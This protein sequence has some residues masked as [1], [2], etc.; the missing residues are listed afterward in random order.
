MIYLNK[1]KI[2]DIFLYVLDTLADWEI[3]FLIAEI[4]SGRNLKKDIQLPKIIK[5]NYLDK[6]TWNEVI[7]YGRK[8]NIPPEQLDFPIFGL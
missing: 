5:F 3:A 2:M 8:L 4:N 7:D 1:E 6:N